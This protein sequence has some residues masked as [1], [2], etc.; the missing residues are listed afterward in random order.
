MISEND[1]KLATPLVFL[2]AT[3][4]DL[5]QGA[6][7]IHYFPVN[8]SRPFSSSRASRLK[9]VLFP[10]STA[11]HTGKETYLS[12]PHKKNLPSPP[13]LFI[14]A[15][16]RFRKRFKKQSK[17]QSSGP[18]VHWSN[19]YFTPSHRKQR[20]FLFLGCKPLNSLSAN[21]TF[22]THAFFKEPD[23]SIRNMNRAALNNF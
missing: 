20:R 19:P 12:F 16:N 7:T 2:W 10:P 11:H 1:Y 14:F 3:E 17:K 15:K 9:S 8:V 22:Q 18:R 5:V 4:I 13:K 21:L 6:G 23:Y